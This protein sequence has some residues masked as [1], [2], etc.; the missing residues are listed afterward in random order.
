MTSVVVIAV[1]ATLVRTIGQARDRV[2][3]ISALHGARGG[4][5]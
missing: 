4:R 5:E 2:E 3:R 1:W